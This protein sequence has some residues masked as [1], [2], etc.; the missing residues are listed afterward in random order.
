MSVSNLDEEKRV[1][2]QLEEFLAATFLGII[3]LWKK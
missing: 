1:R 3:S 2:T